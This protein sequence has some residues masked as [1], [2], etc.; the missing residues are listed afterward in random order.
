MEGIQPT[1]N[2]ADRGYDM[3]FGGS[4]MWLFALLILFGLGGNGFGRG[5]R[6]ATTE[7]LASGFNFSG[8]NNKLNEITAGIAGVNQNLGNAICSSTYELASKIDNCG[9]TTQRAIDSVKF[10]MANY[11]SAINAN[12]TAQTQKILDAISQSKIE[13]LQAQVSKL[14]LEQA[15]CGVVRY[16]T[17]SVYANP[18]NPFAGSGCGY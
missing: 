4:G 11:S 13:S 9:C 10:D 7:D 3:G 15:L 17:S 6:A 16:P 2:L 12:T 18:C 5:E 14:Q 8:V 1:Y